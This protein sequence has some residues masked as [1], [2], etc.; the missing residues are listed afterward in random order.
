MQKERYLAG[1][2]LVRTYNEAT[3]MIRDE[4]TGKTYSWKKTM[5]KGKYP[6]LD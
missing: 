6:F 2:K 5:K 1:N 3:D 4:R